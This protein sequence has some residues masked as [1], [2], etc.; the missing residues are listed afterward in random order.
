MLRYTLHISKD[1]ISN[2]LMILFVSDAPMIM[3]VLNTLMIILVA[4]Y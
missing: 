1:F 2:T 3:F 4:C